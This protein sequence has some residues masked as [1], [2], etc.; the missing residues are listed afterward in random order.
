MTAPAT[1]APLLLPL[2]GVLVCVA[3]GDQRP[4]GT[5]PS[6]ARAL[7]WRVWNGPTLSGRP[8]EV[9]ICPTCIAPG[10]PG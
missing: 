10:G 3:C 9:V 5:T 2:P 1:P 8:S 7:G 4:A 6:D